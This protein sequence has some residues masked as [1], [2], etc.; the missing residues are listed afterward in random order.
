MKE[1]ILNH[2]ELKFDVNLLTST[3]P[4]EPGLSVFHDNTELHVS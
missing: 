4:Q 1:T 2:V 3:A